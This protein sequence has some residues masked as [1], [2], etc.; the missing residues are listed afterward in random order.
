MKVIELGCIYCG[1]TRRK[2]PATGEG[3][4]SAVAA[5][6]THLVESHWDLL[7]FGRK[8]RLE[9]GVPVNDAWTRI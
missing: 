6:V 7:E 3:V 4:R 5:Y 2:D 8:Q 1:E 9:A